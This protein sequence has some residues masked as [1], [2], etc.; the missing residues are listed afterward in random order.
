VLL[1][2]YKNGGGPSIADFPRAR[3]G[4]AQRQAYMTSVAHGR[5]S[6]LTGTVVRF[7]TDYLR[8]QLLTLLHEQ[9][10]DAWMSDRVQRSAEVLERL[11]GR[12]CEGVRAALAW[13][14]G[15]AVGEE[16]ARLRQLLMHDQ[17]LYAWSRLNG[18]L[19]RF[20]RTWKANPLNL[21]LIWAVLVGD[22]LTHLGVHQQTW[23]WLMYPVLVMGGLGHL[24][25]QIEDAHAARAEIT[26]I[27]KPN[28]AGIGE[29]VAR[30]VNKVLLEL[31]QGLVPELSSEY[32][33]SL[34]LKKI[35]R[36]TRPAMEDTCSIQTS[37]NEVY[38]SPSSGDFMRA[39]IMDE[40]SRAMDES[41]MQSLVT[42][43]LPRDSMSG[44]GEVVK[45]NESATRGPREKG[46][47]HQ[48]PGLTMFL[49][50]MASNTNATRPAIEECWKSLMRAAVAVFASG[51]QQSPGLLQ[52]RPRKRR[53]EGERVSGS[54]GNPMLPGSAAEREHLG[55]L[56]SAMGLISRQ[57]GLLNKTAQST[58]EISPM[59]L[60]VLEWFKDIVLRERLACFFGM[61]LGQ[62][63]DRFMK[64]F[65]SRAVA[66]CHVATM[67]SCVEQAATA[68]D[69]M[70]DGVL[71]M[72]SAALTLPFAGVALLNGVSHLADFGLC[73]VNQ[74]IR[75]KK[76]TP[77][78]SVDFL[79]LA[80]DEEGPALEE[81][82]RD[83]VVLRG[84]LEGLRAARD[85]LATG[86]F[87]GSYM[88][89][90]GLGAYKDYAEVEEYLQRYCGVNQ[91]SAFT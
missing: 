48:L 70:L 17:T 63:W 10:R 19:L 37:N 36:G 91:G 32:L 28:G 55:F 5:P 13:A 77:V 44:T 84:F 1:D 15:E 83:W 89:V 57:V 56:L 30:A 6:R 62:N 14:G 59:V 2:M 42:T 69:G 60:D 27:I 23:L 85:N 53:L 3:M 35:D 7:Y 68:K 50:V 46:V 54:H 33:A 29:V 66:S 20:N 79:C 41:A 26:Y 75:Q 49:L 45:S 58:W 4:E 8:L 71:E 64:G 24:K 81:G 82:C 47:S 73:A 87:Q 40:I 31:L 72:E 11:E 43:V 39:V 34:S 12:L 88:K 76:E 16:T 9:L 51:A 67:T 21:T 65:V 61:T 80:L 52:N 90:G 86:G 22:V 25:A 18:G 74:L 78:L 38:G